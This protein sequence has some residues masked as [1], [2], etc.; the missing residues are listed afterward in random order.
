MH[1]SEGIHHDSGEPLGAR[2][3]D[4]GQSPFDSHFS[5]VTFQQSF[6][7][8]CLVDAGVS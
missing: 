3:L 2:S 5:A 6:L 4:F 1:M 8:L 7:P